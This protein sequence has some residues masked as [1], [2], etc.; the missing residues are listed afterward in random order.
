MRLSDNDLEMMQ[1]AA[2]DLDLS[3]ADDDM[4]EAAEYLQSA[5]ASLEDAKS[6]PAGI[7]GF[8]VSI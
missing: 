6:V 8:E 5:L 3:S 1:L 7:M 2:I 4:R